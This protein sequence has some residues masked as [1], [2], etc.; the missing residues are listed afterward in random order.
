MEILFLS[1]LHL[2]PSRPR[3]LARFLKLLQSA[4]TRAAAIYILGDLFEIWVG[5]DHPQA[6]TPEVE[7]ALGNYSGSGGALYLLR[8][9]RDFLL[10]QRFARRVGA[11]LLP[12]AS[13]IDLG[14]VPVLLMHGDALC[15]SD[16]AY[17]WYRRAVDNP[18]FKGCF[19]ALPGSWRSR[20][21]SSFRRRLLARRDS[22]KQKPRVD[23]EQATVEKI[24]IR[25]QVH[26]LIHGHVHRPGHHRFELPG[27]GGQRWV[28]GDWYQGDSLLLW[29]D[30]ELQLTDA[31]RYLGDHGDPRAGRRGTATA[32]G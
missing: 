1:D 21:A 18:L 24:M 6:F 16:H 23:V 14:G 20:L 26:I 7:A 25:H 30:G 15:T 19:L 11:R 28:L 12:D 17:Q 9:N 13:K 27:G 29:R 31:A 2:D 3:Q 32:K 5:D 8:G 4:A 10:G 22:L